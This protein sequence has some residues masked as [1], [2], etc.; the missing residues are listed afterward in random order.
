MNASFFP[1]TLPTVY[2]KGSQICRGPRLFR[3][4]VLMAVA[5]WTCGGIDFHSNL[6]V[7]VGY[8]CCF[9]TVKGRQPCTSK[10]FLA[11]RC[12]WQQCILSHHLDLGNC[13]KDSWDSICKKEEGFEGTGLA[14]SHG[15]HPALFPTRN[16]VCNVT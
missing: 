14:T 6:L 5:I 7:G 2:W 16:Q 11:E 9:H 8:G 10:N 3:L 15:C 4:M 13:C 1:K 12:P